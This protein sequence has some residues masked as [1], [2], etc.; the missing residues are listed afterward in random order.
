[1]SNLKFFDKSFK[2]KAGLTRYI[3]LEEKKLITL[4]DK[5]EKKI[6]ELY[7]KENIKK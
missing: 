5:L 1:M 7:K 4:Q 2:N 3:N 6:D